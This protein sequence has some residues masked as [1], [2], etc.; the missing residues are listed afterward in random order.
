MTSAQNPLQQSSGSNTHIIVKTQKRAKGN[1]K[2]LALFCVL[3]SLQ[4]Q[5]LASEILSMERGISKTETS[6]NL[7]ERNDFII[8]KQ[9]AELEHIETEA[10]I[11]NSR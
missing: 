3:Y 7:L 8:E 4:M 11:R 1:K 10:N 2:P 6:K 5:T 9:R